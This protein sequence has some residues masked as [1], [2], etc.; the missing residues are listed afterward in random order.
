MR[1]VNGHVPLDIGFYRD[2]LDR[3]WQTF[4]AERLLYGSDWPN[5]DQWAQY[6]DVFRL[7]QAFISSKPPEDVEKFFWKNSLAVYGWAKR[8]ASQP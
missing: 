2:R 5:S 1:T 7:A 3:I 4:G 6:P 8:D